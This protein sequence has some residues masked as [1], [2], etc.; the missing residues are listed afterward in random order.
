[1]YL[2]AGQ[3]KPNKK[4]SDYKTVFAVVLFMSL[5]PVHNSFA[6][7]P[8]HPDLLKRMVSDKL[9]QEDSY[10]YRNRKNFK[11]RG[12][13]APWS[14]PVSQLR[15][16]SVSETG[17]YRQ[18]GPSTSPGG[19]WNALVLLVEFPDKP[20]QTDPA[21][22][23]KILFSK[24]YKSLTDYYSAVSYGALDI[25]TRD[26]PSVTKWIKA[27]QNFS[28]YVNNENGTGS[29]PHNCQK[30]VEDIIAVA[31]PLVDFSKYD[32]DKDGYVDALIVVH[33]GV[34][35]EFSGKNS[36]IW[37]HAWTL[38]R[39]IT[40]DGVKLSRYSTDPEYYKKPGDMTMGV[41]AH[42]LGHAAFGVPD[43]YDTDNSSEGLGD[44]SLMAG[45]SWNGTGV[46]GNSPAYPDAWTRMQMGYL[47]PVTI[48]SETDKLEIPRIDSVAQAYRI[49]KNKTSWEY[50]LLENRQLTGY[51]KYL[52]GKGLLIY[53][54][55]ESK[56]GV[57]NDE[58]WY[59]G[60]DSTK[61]YRVAL[62]QA[63]ASWE[64]EKGQNQGNAGDPFPG[65]GGKKF[66]SNLSVP[67]SRDYMNNPTWVSLY[68]IGDN[69]SVIS[70][71]VSFQQE[72]AAPAVFRGNL[73]AVTGKVRLEWNFSGNNGN[74]I[75]FSH[76]N[77]YRDGTLIA[78]PIQPEFSEFLYESGSYQYTVSAVY[79]LGE[80]EKTGP[81]ILKKTNFDITWSA[82]LAI[83]DRQNIS[84]AELT[85][86]QA[87]TASD[88]IDTG[89]DENLVP[90]VP[91]DS[92]A[93]N[94]RF[95]LPVTPEKYSM[96]DFRKEGKDTLL[97]WR[98]SLNPAAPVEVKW[99]KSRLPAGKFTLI[100]YCS[101]TASE[102]EMK[103]HDSCSVAA[104]M[105]SLKIV[106]NNLVPAS[107]TVAA[108]WNMVSIP[109]GI[110]EQTEKYLIRDLT[111]PVYTYSD[112]YQQVT[113]LE[114]GR[115]YW[116]KSAASRVFP[117]TGSNIGVQTIPVKTGWNMIGL[118]NSESSVENISSTPDGIIVSQYYE[119]GSDYNISSVL[120]P[121]K[122]YWVKVN[123][124]GYLVVP[125]NTS[126][127]IWRLNNNRR[128]DEVFSLVINDATGKSRT[129]T[130]ASNISDVTR[131]DMPPVP[132]GGVFDV[133]WASNRRIE[134][135]EDGENIIVLNSAQYPVTITA[136]GNAVR[137]TD[138][139]GGT[140]VNKTLQK[141]EQ[142]KINDSS[143]EKLIVT[144][145]DVPAVFSLDQNYPNP[146]NPSTTIRFGIPEDGLVR[147]TV[148]DIL[149]Q[150][151]SDLVNTWMSAGYHKV[152]W[153]G[154]D[155][156][157]GIYYYELQCGQFSAFRKM[158]LLK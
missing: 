110:S 117:L 134:T 115:G 153:N 18:F 49:W 45:G 8:P 21:H 124:D 6:Q 75:V 41:F 97:T 51:D 29:Y 79:N 5:W 61:H 82:S 141:G 39:T 155:I 20:A 87:V 55:D 144:A 15:R 33:A 92:A 10:Y 145:V 7:M 11:S 47:T 140:I 93:L 116:L 40:A 31:N 130:M 148:Y 77:V 60:K 125:A 109:V 66:F 104:G 99:D 132:P 102:L 25:V 156:A 62:E 84:S 23:D 19:T 157:S 127:R 70:L 44:W 108:G 13:D 146:F 106:Y 73:N 135:P 113:D 80:S 32:N 68:N 1:M 142:L 94:A 69:N 111:A 54:I 129:L 95:I 105:D 119:Y 120:Q 90:S 101:G 91:D 37:S 26:L 122:G 88:G 3:K 89:L 78:S 76:F 27:P 131:Y 72:L 100:Y 46:G 2:S 71:N 38:S 147:L 34:G 53:H 43:L 114:E 48:G 16:Q 152:D 42:E 58:E 67:S 121:G 96:K 138:I 12:I 56:E 126:P 24:D 86:G 50:F 136:G 64:L 118:Y 107:V 4:F 133:R 139:A 22:F 36:D 81:V 98:I 52:P 85:F 57:D 65:T 59:P 112:G 103:M 28:Y 30:L 17:V 9:Y 149:G 137:I 14:T 63:D 158:L 143:V 150:K 123:A 83:S 154:A 35:A 74:G 128:L 151:V